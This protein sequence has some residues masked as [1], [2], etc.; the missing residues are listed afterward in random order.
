MLK[1]FGFPILPRLFILTITKTESFSSW[2]CPIFKIFTLQRNYPMMKVQVSPAYN[3]YI[4]N[5]AKLESFE[6]STDLAFLI[7]FVYTMY[8]SASIFKIKCM[9]TK[10]IYAAVQTSTTL[11]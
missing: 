4:N 7:L 11:T 1:I 3:I 8:P 5:L 6:N 9:P 10:L 2:I